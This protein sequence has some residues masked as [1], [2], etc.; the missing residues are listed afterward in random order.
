MWYNG[1]PINPKEVILMLKEYFV[2]MYNDETYLLA[3]RE[4]NIPANKLAAKVSLSPGALE[5]LRNCSWADYQELLRH[6]FD[7]GQKLVTA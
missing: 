6:Y 1:S 7:I 5:N 3:H 4:D 2:Y